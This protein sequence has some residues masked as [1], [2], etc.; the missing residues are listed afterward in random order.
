MELLF[1]VVV[2]LAAGDLDL[3]AVDGLALLAAGL[4]L[5]DFLVAAFAPDLL[6]AAG[7]EVEAIR[8]FLL[9]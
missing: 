4:F 3:L 5:E 9:I 2:F 7:L 6:P 8:V 1:R